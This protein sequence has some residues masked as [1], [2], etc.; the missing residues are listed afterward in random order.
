MI[1][2]NGKK[3]TELDVCL[4][5]GIRDG[6]E[7]LYKHSDVTLKHINEVDSMMDNLEQL[8]MNGVDWL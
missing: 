8:V 6:L 3:G 1:E 7:V 4:L 5:S 2:C